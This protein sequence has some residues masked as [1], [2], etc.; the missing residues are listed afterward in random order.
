MDNQRK[1]KIA[2]VLQ[3]CSTADFNEDFLREISIEDLITIINSSS[4]NKTAFRAAWAL[5]HLL[6]QQ[7]NL[8]L[9]Y[10]EDVLHLYYTST[11][12]S[13]LRSVSK[14]TIE[15]LKNPLKYILYVS[16]ELKGKLLNRTF[17]LL[18][19]KQCAIAVRCNTYDIAFL[20]GNDEPLL[21]KELQQYILLD[22]EKEPTAAIKSRATR[23]EKKIRRNI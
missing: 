21:L 11:N 14:L 16:D 22:L 12:W 1:L 10:K 18:E 19:N 4:D 7:R 9:K 6:L 2:A 15:L 17:A 20:L 5:E 23:V 3:T 8:L 13:V